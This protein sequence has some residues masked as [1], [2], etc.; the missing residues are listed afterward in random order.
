MVFHDV[1]DQ[2][3]SMNKQRRTSACQPWHLQSFFILHRPHIRSTEV[4]CFPYCGFNGYDGASEGPFSLYEG[5]F[6][7]LGALE[8]LSWRLVGEIFCFFSDFCSSCVSVSKKHLKK[9]SKWSILGSKIEP[10]SLQNL[11]KNRCWKSW[12]FQHDFVEF[13]HACTLRD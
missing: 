7:L 9:L 12:L 13:S 5:P 2:E 4:C 1:V 3:M 8:T 11:I 10:K 6:S